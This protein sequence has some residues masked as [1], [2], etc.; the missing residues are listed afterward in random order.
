MAHLHT[1]DGGGTAPPAQAPDKPYPL[2][3]FRL[4]GGRVG[5]SAHRERLMALRRLLEGELLGSLLTTAPLVF[6]IAWR[7]AP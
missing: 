6:C 7:G 5:A 4:I 2:Q 3:S 1:H